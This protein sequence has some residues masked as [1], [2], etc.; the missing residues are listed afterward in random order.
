MSYID[1]VFDGP[2]SHES[3]RFVEV[4]NSEGRSIKFGEWVLR[5]DGF[6]ALRVPSVEHLT[7]ENAALGRR[8]DNIKVRAYEIGQREIHDMALNALAPCDHPVHS[9]PGLIIP[10]PECGAGTSNV[11]EQ[12]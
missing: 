1:I 4:E 10:C 3:G 7:A 5:D 2:P 11:K 6:W 8:L 12:P 9:N